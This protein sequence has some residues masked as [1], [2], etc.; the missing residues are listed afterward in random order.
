MSNLLP[1]CCSL[2]ALA[3]LLMSSCDAS[4][5]INKERRDDRNIERPVLS[6]TSNA[7]SP[8]IVSEPEKGSEQA[9]KIFTIEQ[10]GIS[11]RALVDSNG[12]VTI[13]DY[14]M[15][16][17]GRAILREYGGQDTTAPFSNEQCKLIESLAKHGAK[18]LVRTAYFS[19]VGFEMPF[20]LTSEFLP[21]VI[22]SANAAGFSSLSIEITN[23]P[24]ISFAG[25]VEFNFKDDATTK[26]L[27][28]ESEIE[29]QL[30]LTRNGVE[31]EYGTKSVIVFSGDIICDLVQSK[32]EMIVTY[33]IKGEDRVVK[34]IYKVLEIA[35]KNSAREIR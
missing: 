1:Q 28:H 2:P 22:K 3:I 20:F 8:S 14:P 11:L 24:I 21:A 5:S 34:T 16:W 12:K 23:P 4:V 29:E 32:A 17:R 10:D 15:E 31:D 33:P 30:D 6:K 19:Q 13:I 7:E 9:P 25:G 27:G 35:V 26:L 18:D